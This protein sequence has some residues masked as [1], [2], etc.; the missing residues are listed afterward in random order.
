MNLSDVLDIAVT[1]KVQTLIGY[2]CQ[3]DLVL[4]AGSNVGKV[5]AFF[6]L[7]FYGRRKTDTYVCMDTYQCPDGI[8]WVTSGGPP[9]MIPAECLH[10]VLPF[11]VVPGGVRPIFPEAV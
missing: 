6:V 1:T 8:A 10:N 2:V 9:R 11:C 5:S 4:F 7:S 3:H